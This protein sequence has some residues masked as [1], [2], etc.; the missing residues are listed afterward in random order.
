MNTAGRLGLYAAGVAVAFAGAFGI[1]ALVV[2]DVLVEQW[3]EGAQGDEHGDDHGEDHG[4][5][6][7]D[8][9]GEAP[10]STPATPQGLSLSAS[11]FVLS[12][13]SAPASAGE[14]G[15]LSFRILDARGEPVVAFETAHEQDLHLVVVRTDGALFRHVHPTLDAATGVWS[16]PWQWDAAGTYR[17]FADFLPASGADGDESVTLT[18]VVEVAGALVP[19]PPTGPV[20][21]VEVD[22]VEVPVDGAL[23]AGT[24]SELT[25]TVT[26]DG[27]PV[28]T[29]QPYLGAF[30]HLVALREGDLAYLHVHAGGAAPRPGD[31]AGPELSFSVETPTA[32]RYLLY[33]DLRIDGRVSTAALVLDAVPG[34]GAR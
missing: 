12:P 11:G 13:V 9:T 1:A 19:A 3:T 25:I 4:E 22:G 31:T 14:A 29:L 34:E 24:M 6:Q 7:G 16:M 5:D 32:G 21:A 8:A 27:E 2:P 30:G 10:Q 20:S 23:V 17:V 26:R 33:L 18:R 15:E 28:T